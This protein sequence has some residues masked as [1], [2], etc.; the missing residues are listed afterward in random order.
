LAVDDCYAQ[1]F[2]LRSIKQHAFH[3]YTPRPEGRSRPPCQRAAKYKEA[4]GEGS[5]G[6][7]Y[8]LLLRRGDARRRCPQQGADGINRY[9]RAHFYRLQLHACGPLGRHGISRAKCYNKPNRSQQTNQDFDTQANNQPLI[10]SLLH[11]AYN[12]SGEQR[13]ALSTPSTSEPPHQR[14][15]GTYPYSSKQSIPAFPTRYPATTAVQPK[16]ARKR[17]YTVFPIE[18]AFIAGP[19]GAPLC[20]ISF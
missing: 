17:A 6:G 18:Y 1:L 16:L 11:E 2:L 14:L 13:Q 8:A 19:T 5:V 10:T 9:C 7:G 12:G 20:K 15:A 3:L 4:R